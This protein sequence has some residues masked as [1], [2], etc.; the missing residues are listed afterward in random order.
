MEHHHLLEVQ[1]VHVS[2][3]EDLRL[4]TGAGKYASDWN[5]PGQLSAYFLRADR[6]H[7]KIL[8]ID[9]AAASRQPGVVRIYTGAD[10]VRA[11]YVKP[12][13][14]LTFK[15]IGGMEVRLP[16]RPALAYGRVRCVGEPVAM[17]VA[18]SALAAQD[19]AE[20]IDVQYEDLPV[21]TDPE[22]AFEPGAPQLHDNV[23]G[24]APFEFEAGDAAA[25]EAAF[26]RAKHV[27]RL[28]LAV[29][30]V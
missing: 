26:A 11:G 9:S 17:V 2:R 6:A 20:L 15:G 30:R 25:T 28:K 5:L 4:I 21:V 24:N 7:A 16:E 19:A 14:M 10:T 23:P 3:R 18:E 13:T 29:T 8:S 27:T 22:K 12:M 1:G